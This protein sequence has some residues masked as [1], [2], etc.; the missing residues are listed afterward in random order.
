VK[1]QL[2][3]AD[4]IGME[5]AAARKHFAAIAL[6]LRDDFLAA[7]EFQAVLVNV[8]SGKDYFSEVRALPEHFWNGMSRT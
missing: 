4:K 1:R 3:I 5:Q 2:E 6:Y 7:D 8:K